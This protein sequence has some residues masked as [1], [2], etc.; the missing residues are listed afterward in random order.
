MILSG[1]RLRRNRN[2]RT[3]IVESPEAPP[4]HQYPEPGGFPRR[5]KPPV[6]D[7]QVDGKRA[8]RAPPP[9]PISRPLLSVRLLHESRPTSSRIVYLPP[10]PLT[11][12]VGVATSNVYLDWGRR[13]WMLGSVAVVLDA[14]RG[15][16]RRGLSTK[17]STC[18]GGAPTVTG[19]CSSL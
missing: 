8:N 6:G 3:L 17:C 1:K 4:F 14:K 10:H 5:G 2:V 9:L 13:A 19:S 18:R 15:W 11:I 12:S 7:R 16:L